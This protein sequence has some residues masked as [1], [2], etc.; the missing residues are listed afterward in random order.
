MYYTVE[1][2]RVLAGGVLDSTETLT[3]FA[4]MI[5]LMVIVLSWATHVYKKAV[6]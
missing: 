6:A 2:S 5:P 3:A 1:A 4:V